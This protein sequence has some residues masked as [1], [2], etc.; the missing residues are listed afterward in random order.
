MI[1]Q[2]TVTL[3]H[4][5]WLY[6]FVDYLDMGARG[7]GLASTISFFTLMAGMYKYTDLRVD[8]NIR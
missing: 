3:L 7:A 8:Q 2:G 5:P 1:I 6:I 4:I